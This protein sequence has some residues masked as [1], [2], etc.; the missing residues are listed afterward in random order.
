MRGPGFCILALALTTGCIENDIPYPVVE[1]YIEQIA[2]EGLTGDP[3]IDR[4]ARRVVL[5]LEETTDIQAVEITSC[6]ITDKAVASEEIVGV[7]NLLTPLYVTLSIYQ[8]YPWTVEAQQT[9]ERTFTVA[10]QIGSTEWNPANLTAKAYVGF[11]D[12]SHVEVTALKLGPRGITTMACTDVPDL[13]ETNLDLLSD[14]SKD[15]RWVEATYHGRTERWYLTVEYSEIKV[16]LTKVAPW[17]HSVW[18]YAD[19]LNG[20]ELGFRY[21]PEGTEEWIEVPQEQIEFN[22]GSFSTQIKGLLPETRYEVIAYSNDDLTAVETFTT[23]AALPLPN[24]GFEEWSTQKSI[25]CPYLTED[26]AFWHS[27][28]TGAK[29]ASKVICDGIEDPRPGSDGRYAAYL[30]STLATVVG[31]GKFAAGNIFVGTYV[32]TDGTNGIINFGRPFATHPIA[33]RGWM[34]CHPGQIDK[35]DKSPAGMTLTTDDMDEGSIY[36]A[37]GTWTPEEYGG[38]AESPVQVSTKNVTT[39]FNKNSKDVIG[40][41]ELILTE[42]VDE[43]TQFTIEIDWRDRTTQPTHMMI[44]CS[45]S[46]WGDYFTG[47][48]KSRMWVDDFELIYDETQLE[49]HE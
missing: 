27:G 49:D 37:L 30:E 8:E 19:G 31:I 21:R 23:E 26:Q 47:S 14:F 29:I 4:A 43:W 36:I 40:Y 25:I 12:L 10:E 35:V 3:T 41:G 34:K 22:G 38:T 5:P 13:N 33:L 42:D 15:A 18:L 9:I 16:T 39:F 48:S 1:C 28:N 20:T 6:T 45:A 11:E 44:V 32:K 2:A 46:R 17:T 7:H 24:G